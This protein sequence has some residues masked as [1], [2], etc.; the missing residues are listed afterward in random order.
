MAYWQ[1]KPTRYKKYIANRKNNCDVRGCSLCRLSAQKPAAQSG[2]IDINHQVCL[3]C[4]VKKLLESLHN[5]VGKDERRYIYKK[6]RM[7]RVVSAYSWEYS[8]VWTGGRRRKEEGG[9]RKEEGGRRKEAADET[10][11]L[12]EDKKWPVS[13]AAR[14]PGLRKQRAPGAYCTENLLS[15]DKSRRLCKAT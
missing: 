2:A 14:S 12:S 6:K 5:H 9:R 8:C 15:I 7:K 3:C 13:G 4:L 11:N 1:Y 10:V